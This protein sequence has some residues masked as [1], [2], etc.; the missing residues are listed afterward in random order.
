MQLKK[1]QIPDY[2]YSI[3]NSRRR[4]SDNLDYKR[5]ILETHLNFQNYIEKLQMLLYLEEIWMKDNIKKY[6]ISD[7]VFHKEMELFTLEMSGFSENRPSVRQGDIL[8]V[9]PVGNKEMRYW[10]SVHSVQHNSVKIKFFKSMDQFVEGMKFN[11][12]FTVKN[13]IMRLQHRALELAY[14]DRLMSVLFPNPKHCGQQHNELPK[15]RLFNT[16][17]EDNPRQYQAIQHIMAGSSRP[18]PY[19]IYGPPGTGKT[20]TMAEAIKQ[21]ANNCTS[22][23]IKILA[24]ASTNSACDVLCENIVGGNEDKSKVYRMYAKYC[25][26]RLVPEVLKAYSNLDRQTFVFPEKKELMK[27]KIIVTTP[28]TAGRLV[29]EDFPVGHFTHV[30]FDEAGHGLETE[31]LIA[32]AGLLCPMKGQVVLAGDPNQL[33]PIVRSH[34]AKKNGM[35]VSLLERLMKLYTKKKM[36]KKSFY[37]KLQFNY[38]SHPSILQIPNQLFY[39]GALFAKGDEAKCYSCCQW[40]HLPKKGFPLIFHSVSGVEEKEASSNSIFNTAEKDMIISYV[41]KL[42]QTLDNISPQDIGI[43]TPYRKQVQK[44]QEGLEI[45]GKEYRDKP[46]SAVKVGT[47]E[48]FQEDERKVILVSTVHSSNNQL[49]KDKHFNLGVIRSKK[50]FNVVLTRAM[51]LLIVVG[52]LEVLKSDCYWGKFIEYCEENGAILSTSNDTSNQ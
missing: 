30:F 27:Y 34:L 11:V 49:K 28:Y 52:D 16:Q 7:A 31:C 1:Y 15:L 51:A 8:S 29:T 17:V 32:L 25:D 26:S 41:K 50:K 48:E 40:K 45:V 47:V 35:E 39:R 10:G 22:T 20:V 42:L 13:L 12:E 3:Y 44:I 2:M 38:R 14:E 18:A 46:W 9:Y 19:L 23:S 36:L 21:I 6:N 5:Q 33:G 43:I 4:Q 37:T 24:C